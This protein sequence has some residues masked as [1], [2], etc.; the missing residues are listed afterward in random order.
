M[1]TGL[2]RSSSIFTR[3]AFALW[4]LARSAVGGTG[5]SDEEEE[6]EDEEDD[7]EEEGWVWRGATAAALHRLSRNFCC[8]GLCEGLP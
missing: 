4:T 3:P 8:F 2:Y 6:E 7:D 5:P 1:T